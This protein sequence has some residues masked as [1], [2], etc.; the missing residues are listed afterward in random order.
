MFG[1][2]LG[3]GKKSPL[4]ISKSLAGILDRM[5]VCVLGV[6]KVVLPGVNDDIFFGM[7]VSPCY[8]VS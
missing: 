6:V 4:S 2:L 7:C 3:L 8:F 1:G 5:D